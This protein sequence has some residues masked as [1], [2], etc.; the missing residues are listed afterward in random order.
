MPIL[1][2]QKSEQSQ[3]ITITRPSPT[4]W[5][6]LKNCIKKNAEYLFSP[7]ASDSLSFLC[8]VSPTMQKTQSVSHPLDHPCLFLQASQVGQQIQDRAAAGTAEGFATMQAERETPC[9]QN[10]RAT[11]EPFQAAWIKSK[12]SRRGTH[13]QK[14]TCTYMHLKKKTILCFGALLSGFKFLF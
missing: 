8:S 9:D 2:R 7:T 1:T 3:S 5:Q 12:Q 10:S 13:F 6:H 4:V 14:W 11:L